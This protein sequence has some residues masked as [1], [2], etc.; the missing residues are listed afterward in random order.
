MATHILLVTFVG[1]FFLCLF[2]K[3]CKRRKHPVRTR[4]TCLLRPR[5]GAKTILEL[6]DFTN[7]IWFCRRWFYRRGDNLYWRPRHSTWEQPATSETPSMWSNLAK[8]ALGSTARG[9]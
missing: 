8:P 7:V 5:T 4:A 1:Y 2:I 9:Y 3:D 6:D